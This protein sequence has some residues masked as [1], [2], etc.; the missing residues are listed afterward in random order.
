MGWNPF[1]AVANVVSG[2]ASAVT[3]V[4]KSVLN[5]ATSA[6]NA[7]VGA[8]SSVVGGLLGFLSPTP[9]MPTQQAVDT[10]VR[11]QL[12]PN[13]D[14]KI[15]VV[16][17]SA[18]V[19]GIITDARISDNNKVMTYVLTLCEKTTTGTF[20]ISE[21]YW[22]DIKLNI[23][24]QYY[25]SGSTLT[26]HIRQAVTSAV[27][28]D[29]SANT[30]LVVN[31]STKQARIQIFRYLGSSSTP[32][33]GNP[34]NAWEVVP[35]WT[36]QHTMDN[37]IF[38]VVKIRYDNEKGITGLPTMTFRVENTLR[39]PGDVWY[40]YLTNTRYGCG[41]DP[42]EVDNDARNALNSVGSQNISVI[43][44]TVTQISNAISD[45]IKNI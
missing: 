20:T 42:A 6:V 33:A 26:T 13:T 25:Y 28:A 40:D 30:D 45:V 19:K 9:D 18:Y 16:Y 23:S 8:V 39:Q 14:N 41:I 22:N 4:A 37:L 21:I 27:N 12:S 10:G 3:S 5:I 1:K 17:G 43:T 35:E 2:V 38:V 36:P 24:D 31:N 7:V 29:G 32:Q 34:Y 11:V 15:P 44:R